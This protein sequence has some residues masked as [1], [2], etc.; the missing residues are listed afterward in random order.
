MTHPALVAPAD[1]DW[2]VSVV[3]S[4]GKTSRYRVSPGSL[5]PEEAIRRALRSSGIPIPNVRE[6]SYLRAYDHLKISTTDIDAQFAALV[7]DAKRRAQC[8]ETSSYRSEA[9]SV[10]SVR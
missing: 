5:D 1:T 2:I 7:E 3:S 8:L 4:D 9:N 6:V 10:H